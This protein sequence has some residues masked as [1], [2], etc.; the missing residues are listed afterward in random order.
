MN[1]LRALNPDR[2]R[3]LGWLGGLSLSGI[4]APAGAAASREGLEP[5][6]GAPVARVE[7]VRETLWG[8]TIV[9]PYRWMERPEDPDW[10][11]F[12][13]GQAAHAR[14][15]LEAIPGHRA[16][17]AR[18]GAL[19]S[20][21]PVVSATV[22]AGGRVF[23]EERAAG[24]SQFRLMVREGEAGAARVLVDTSQQRIGGAHVSLDWWV[25][26][27]D[28]RR[29]AH[30]VSPAGSE[31]SVLQVI[32]V[33]S[34]R[35]LPDRIDRTPFG[36]PSWLPDGSGFFYGRL[37]PDGQAGSAGYFLDS[38]CWLHR[39]G[40]DPS[41]DRRMLARGQYEGF[42]I[43]RNEFPA[44]WSDPSSAWAL[45]AAW[46][47]VR[48][49]QAFFITRRDELLAGRARWTRI[50]TL[51]D[52]VSEIALRGDELFLLSTRDAPNGQ[53]LRTTASA[54]DLGRAARLVPEGP[55]VIEGISATRDA[56]YLRDSRAGYGSLRRLDGAGRLT[57]LEAPFEGTIESISGSTGEA[58][59]WV[60]AVGWLQPM[61]TWRHD[62][63]GRRLRTVALAPEPTIDLGLE[64]FQAL[65]SEAVAR[66]GTRVPISIVAPRRIARNGRLPA[67]VEAYGAY[68]TS[69]SPFFVARRLA[70]LE[71]GALMVTAH[72]RGGG[73]FG[74]SWWLG[75]KDLDK[76]NTWRDLVDCC[77]TLVRE[78]W[79]APRR[80]AIE[81]G[82]AGG[83]TVGRAM[84]ERPA[85]FC[86]VISQVGVNNA[87]RAEFSQN[88]PPNID[89]FGTVTERRGFL[90][91]RQMD[92]LQ[93]VRDDQRY[94]AVLLTTGMTDPR[95]DPWQ[96]A[97]LAARLQAV[98]RQRQPVLLRVDFDAGH[99]IGSTREQVDALT[100]DCTAFALW[101]AGQALRPPRR[102]A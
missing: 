7:P 85:L 84:T 99:G 10:L 53:L 66:D 35:L 50:C 27:P 42:P 11:P 9:D 28:G 25:P 59:L 24:G 37:S 98:P 79:T 63:E 48:R 4:A 90:A 96:V 73:E 47:G 45:G 102:G 49:E 20:G 5:A 29:V 61:A 18:M 6:G 23:Y 36:T 40:E 89:E 74:R 75:G 46:G 41:R 64:R 19:S 43:E 22:S 12:M 81:G 17:A 30:G 93:S 82:S 100:A 92:V 72:V 68:Q 2:R 15:V 51:D 83:I 94:P 1:F 39:L 52:Q 95:V 57:E 76:P 86:A 71:Q 101:R 54:P 80:L 58:G 8:E 77:E 60:Q 14:R 70:F 69:S 26:S 31:Q 3:V 67:L 13:Q 56:L 97:K 88:G 55:S 44:V 87:L 78:G 38:A 91:L 16:Y 62:G 34:G 65:R 21:V 33:A 32:E